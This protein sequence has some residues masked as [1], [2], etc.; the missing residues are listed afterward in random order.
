MKAFDMYKKAKE[1]HIKEMAEIYRRE[2]DPRAYQALI[3]Y[4][5]DIND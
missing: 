4:V 5:V 1:I 3:D 2:I